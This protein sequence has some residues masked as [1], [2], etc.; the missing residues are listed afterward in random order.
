MQLKCNLMSHCPFSQFCSFNSSSSCSRTTHSISMSA[1]SR[2]GNI[3]NKALQEGTSGVCQREW[4][5]VWNAH[6]IFAFRPFGRR[7]SLHSLLVRS[8]DDLST[9]GSSKCMGL[10]F[11]SVCVDMIPSVWTSTECV[12]FYH[13]E[14]RDHNI[15]VDT[16]LPKSVPLTSS[17]ERPPKSQKKCQCHLFEAAPLK[18]SRPEVRSRK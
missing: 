17:L 5:D 11:A 12:D 10:P 15:L 6:I 18:L 14:Q 7:S 3:L 16:A 1:A 8:L 2:P 4:R 9:L 13:Y